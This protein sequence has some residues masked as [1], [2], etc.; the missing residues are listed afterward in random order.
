LYNVIHET[1]TEL[2][3][4]SGWEL[5]EHKSVWK[6]FEVTKNQG[7]IQPYIQS[8]VWFNYFCDTKK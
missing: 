3:A 8:K 6:T 1:S 5:K 7:L 4:G 2:S